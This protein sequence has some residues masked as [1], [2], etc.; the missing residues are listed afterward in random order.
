MK[1]AISYI[2]SNNEFLPLLLF[3]CIFLLLGTNKIISADSQKTIDPAI[4]IEKEVIW[5]IKA[6]WD[7]GSFWDIKAIDSEGDFL[8]VKAI[9]TED[10]NQMM[11]VK[12]FLGD[13]RIPVKVLLSDDVFAPV[14]AI[15]DDGT[16]Y[17]IKALS[18]NGEKLD[19]KGVSRAGN[20]IHIKAISSE[21]KFLPV[22]AISPSGR[23][24]DIKGIKMFKENYELTIYGVR[25]HAHV[26]SLPQA[27]MV[28]DISNWSV[29][30]ILPDGT[31]SEV[32]AIDENGNEYPIK[33]VQNHRQRILLDVKAFI[34][35]EHIPVKLIKTKEVTLIKA[36]G[37][38]GSIYDVK[39]ILPSG[40]K[41]DVIGLEESGNI[42]HVKAINNQGEIFGI[43]AISSEGYLNDVKGVKMTKNN[44]ELLVF[45]VKVHSHLKAVMPAN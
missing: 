41:L 29:I 18:P 31:S 43:K 34:G 45:G 25:V 22:K 4:P 19:V 37:K 42:T 13:K 10:H 26:K 5:H 44:I 2:R 7:D 17:D 23:L 35:N 8:D 36:I 12:A 11:D 33:A 16:I 24:N 40:E 39:S 3:V 32:K 6:I 1:S 15:D 9:Q 30:T 14:K 20:I 38:D 28:G 27:G 21:R